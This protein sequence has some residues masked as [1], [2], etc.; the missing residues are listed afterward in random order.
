MSSSCTIDR[1]HLALLATAEAGRADALLARLHDVAARR[2][3]DAI[4]AGSVDGAD[5]E[6]YLFIDHLSFDCVLNAAWDDDT[7]AKIF[8]KDFIR[9]LKTQADGHLARRFVDRAEF[10]AGFLIALADGNA[11]QHWWFE[12]FDGLRM[13]PLSA[14][15]R[16][17]IANEGEAG[18]AALVRLTS[19]AARRVLQALSG[20]DAERLLA[21]LTAAGT[22]TSFG[23]AALRAAITSPLAETLASPAQRSLAALIALERSTPGAAGSA[24]LRTLRWLE[25][26][27]WAASTGK[28]RAALAGDLPP[29][30]ALM[31]CCDVPGIETAPAMAW[32]DTEL[33][34]LLNELR[35]LSPTAGTTAAPT[36]D[37]GHEA[38][39][40]GGAWLLLAQLAR[41]GWWGRWQASLHADGSSAEIERRIA[42]L[43]L[44][45]VAR[46]VAGDGHSAVSGDDLLQRALGAA[47]P[48]ARAVEPVGG[49]S[50]A[51][52]L[53]RALALT[54]S[55][56]VSA[57]P[58][59]G[60][61]SG[62]YTTTTLGAGRQRRLVLIE[63][64]H[65]TLVGIYR[66]P[67]A[68]QEIAAALPPDA[69]LVSSL[70][71]D[72]AAPE[73]ARMAAALAW[74]HAHDPLA[75]P[76][77]ALDRALHLAAL[78]LLREFSSR[79]PGCGD[80]SA[81]YLRSQCLTMPAM[82][83][84]GAA[85]IDVKL[86]CPPLDVLL[87]LAG[88]KRSTTALPDGRA[89]AIEA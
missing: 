59:V 37:D 28:L 32:P 50:A 85:R 62:T 57:A 51:A 35:S 86:G 10:V 54:T 14:A 55:V 81:A 77:R 74:W 5:D 58:G 17:V 16:T 43:V 19:E 24:A 83:T 78:N 64:R 36:P 63:A 75:T 89:L 66:P 26:L 67:Y 33:A 38:S 8:A 9:A 87:T 88:A 18:L 65:G 56:P 70:E 7:L 79:L 34:A 80:A 15:L 22:R 47:D 46:A 60:P 30:L 44:A 23:L 68:P 6:S 49:K 76:R 40:W 73:H 82:V 4:A 41:L 25:T 27:R 3:P 20:A 39:P 1:F 2:V 31:Q 45:V 84:V 13:L 61:L 69:L 21:E 29:A 11:D 42:K 71:A 72:G 53:R 48:A 12:E 52:A